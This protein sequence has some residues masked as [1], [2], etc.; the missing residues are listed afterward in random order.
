MRGRPLVI[1]GTAHLSQA[2]SASPWR[3]NPGEAINTL[4]AATKESW[5][6]TLRSAALE[7]HASIA[8]FARTLCELCALGAPSA[9]IQRTQDAI[10]D[11]IQHT[12]VCL[13]WA[14]RLDGEEQGPG[15][16]PESIAPFAPLDDLAKSLMTD[17]FRGGCIGETLAAHA[18]AQQ[19]ETCPLPA[20]SE[21]M[22]TMAEDE[23]RHAA[24]AFDTVAWL[25]SR[26][27]QLSSHAKSLVDEFLEEA[28][29]KQHEQVEPLLEVF[30]AMLA[31]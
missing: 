9:L 11:E 15:A 2:T 21:A 22:A 23:A 13:D 30:T 29:A 25:A 4:D 26:S 24:L 3:S 18:L 16:L 12:Q 20:L 27:A 5:A 14:C 7:E 28:D 19:S 8:A 31:A 10:A 6:H 1:E 17:V